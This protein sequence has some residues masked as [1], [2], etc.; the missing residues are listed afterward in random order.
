MSSYHY[1]YFTTLL[2]Q[3]L[4]MPPLVPL[5]VLLLLS[6]TLSIFTAEKKRRK[7]KHPGDVSFINNHPM[8]LFPGLLLP[9]MRMTPPLI[10]CQRSNSECP[11]SVLPETH[12]HRG[13]LSQPPSLSPPFPLAH[14]EREPEDRRKANTRIIDSG[15][16]HR[17]KEKKKAASSNPR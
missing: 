9:L 17:K 16:K 11:Y 1:Y 2:L 7:K 13:D 4:L 15:R 12:F 6:S 3:Q 8:L 5:L 14:S 10:F